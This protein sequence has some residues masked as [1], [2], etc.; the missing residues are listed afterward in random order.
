MLLPGAL[1]YVYWMSLIVIA[2]S[3]F[4]LISISLASKL[5]LQTCINIHSLANQCMMLMSILFIL[6]MHYVHG[7]SYPLQRAHR[8]YRIVCILQST[9]SIITVLIPSTSLVFL[10]VVHYRAIFWIKFTYKLKIKHIICPAL[11][12]WLATITMA[13]VWTAYHGDYSSWYCLPFTSIASWLSISGQSI[14]TLVCVSSLAVCVGCYYRMIAYLYKEEHVVQAMRS[15]KVSNTRM[16]AK[17][18]TLTFILHMCEG[19]LI[20]SV[21]WLP[22]FGIGMD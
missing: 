22:L 13:A 14:I 12:V 1:L 3:M 2:A 6:I 4:I 8:S 9:L 11:L 16:I 10:T 15:R 18:F 5:N 19:V 20:Q 7:M 17:R 21:V